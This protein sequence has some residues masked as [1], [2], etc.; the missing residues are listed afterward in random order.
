VEHQS[1]QSSSRFLVGIPFATVALRVFRAAWWVLVVF[2][3]TRPRLVPEFLDR[4]GLALPPSLIGW[5][6]AW[7]GVGVGWLNLYGVIG[8]W[9]PQSQISTAIIRM[10]ESCGGR[11]PSALCC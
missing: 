8:G 10:V 9:I 11:T 3:F 1:K 5:L 4:S 6:A 7:L 2:L